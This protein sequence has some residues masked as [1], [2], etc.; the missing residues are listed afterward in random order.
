M[1]T[2]FSGLNEFS[3][4]MLWNLLFLP[5]GFI[6]EAVGVRLPARLYGLEVSG[7]RLGADFFVSAGAEAGI[8]GLPS[9]L[10]IGFRYQSP[11]EMQVFFPTY[12]R[13]TGG[14]HPTSHCKQPSQTYG[15]RR[16]D[17]NSS[18]LSILLSRV[19]SGVN[20]GR[21]VYQTGTNGSVGGGWPNNGQPPT[22]FVLPHLRSRWT[23][24]C[25]A[26]L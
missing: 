15:L 5:Y 6:M 4:Y 26:H 17:S 24:H 16:L 22:R 1:A 12:E 11:T 20:K 13:D 10:W 8:L 14:S 18:I 3:L 9:G 21:T 2:F 7:F 23:Q 25:R 19:C